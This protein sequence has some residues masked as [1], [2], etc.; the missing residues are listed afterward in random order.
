M[1]LAGGGSK[2]KCEW[3]DGRRGATGLGREGEGQRPQQR[4]T[5]LEALTETILQAPGGGV[6]L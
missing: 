2:Q 4:N 6:V 5:C 1:N 3:D